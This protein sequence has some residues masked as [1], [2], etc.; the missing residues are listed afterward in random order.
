VLK[1]KTEQGHGNE[2]I[3]DL[4]LNMREGKDLKGD[5]DMTVGHKNTRV[6]QGHYCFVASFYRLI[7]LNIWAM[8][9]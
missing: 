4:I 7:L 5:E 6:C 2:D 3:L 9:L 8:K 1:Q